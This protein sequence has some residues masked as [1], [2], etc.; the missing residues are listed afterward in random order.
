MN[1]HR[2]TLLHTIAKTA[3]IGA[4]VGVTTSLTSCAV[5]TEAPLPWPDRDILLLGEVHD[6]PEHHRLRA[7]GLR[8]WLT[9]DRLTTVVFEQM[10]RGRNDDI[11]TAVDNIRTGLTAIH[12][13]SLPPLSVAAG[14]IAN[15]GGLD[16]DGWAWPLH[17]PIIEACLAAG[18]R[19][20]GGNLA[21]SGVRAIVRN[22]LADSPADLRR[23]LESE[24]AWSP[25]RQATL[26]Q[27]IDEGHCGALPRSSWPAMVLGQRA[28]DAA[29]ASTLLQA[30]SA[31]GRPRRS[32]LIA[33]NGHVRRD[34]G[35]PQA[36]VAMGVEP[37]RIHSVAYLE[38]GSGGGQPTGLYHQIVYT[39]RRSRPDP[40]EAFRA[41][42]PG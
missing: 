10:D 31:Q 19:I 4:S 11:R 35:V 18:A 24:A 17:R 16:R 32:V 7:E 30:V 14:L 3:A 34:V 40:C 33:G 12:G 27:L 42:R 23:A 2:R 5:P 13:Q 9:A 41:G 6:N 36:L 8:R 22:G 20:Q 26:E 38:Q 21:L 37:R 15:A 1:T 39:A 25:T 28:R 29:M